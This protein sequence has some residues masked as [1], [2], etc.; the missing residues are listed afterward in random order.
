[1]PFKMFSG[2][3]Y[4]TE[5]YCSNL[6]LPDKNNNLRKMH[7]ILTYQMENKRM[8]CIIEIKMVVITFKRYFKVI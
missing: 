8:G 1:V 3:N 4:K 6:Y 5:K 7:S 2:I